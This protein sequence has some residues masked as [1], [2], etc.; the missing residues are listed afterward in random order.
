MQWLGIG[1]DTIFPS[2]KYSLVD[3]PEPQNMCYSHLA[4]REVQEPAPVNNSCRNAV[5]ERSRSCS[6]ESPVNHNG[7]GNSHT[8][9]ADV[10]SSFA[11]L[12]EKALNTA[13]ISHEGSSSEL[14][15]V[16]EPRRRRCPDFD[17]K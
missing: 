16:Q 3:C 12:H 7:S 10:A 6:E 2:N 8:C 1:A 4:F 17:R 11:M 13:A 14:A 9:T 15:R 5:S